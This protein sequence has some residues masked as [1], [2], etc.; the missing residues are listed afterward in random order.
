MRDKTGGQRRAKE[1]DELECISLDS[2][3]I[4]CLKNERSRRTNEQN[5]AVSEGS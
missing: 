4:F 1:E 2:I 3:K 5:K